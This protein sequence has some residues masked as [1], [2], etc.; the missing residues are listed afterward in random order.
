MNWRVLNRT[1][2]GQSPAPTA[3]A[4]SSDLPFPDEE[5]AR[6]NKL[7]DLASLVRTGRLTA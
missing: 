3:R 1:A 7:A 6:V 4:A 5:L 2:R